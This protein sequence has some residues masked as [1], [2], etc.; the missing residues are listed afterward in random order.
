MNG[1]KLEGFIICCFILAIII[2]IYIKYSEIKKIAD[3]INMK[4]LDVILQIQ[5]KINVLLANLKNGF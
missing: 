2:C 1:Y 3:N 5:L 4:E